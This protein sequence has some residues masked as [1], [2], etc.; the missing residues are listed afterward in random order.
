MRTVVLPVS[1]RQK[2]TRHWNGYTEVGLRKT[3]TPPLPD[4][5]TTKGSAVGP[6]ERTHELWVHQQFRLSPQLHKDSGIIE[7]CP[8]YSEMFHLPRMR[9]PFW[10]PKFWSVCFAEFFAQAAA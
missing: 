1:H 7:I 3:Q 9:I 8:I 4:T 2:D 10:T 5:G 6:S